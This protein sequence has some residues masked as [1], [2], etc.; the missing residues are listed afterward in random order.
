MKID[1]TEIFCFDIKN[2]IIIF[3]V[4]G[5]NNKKPNVSVIKPGIISKSA[6]KAIEAPEKISKSGILFLYKL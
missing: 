5:I 2:F 3:L 1:F 6:A 4:N